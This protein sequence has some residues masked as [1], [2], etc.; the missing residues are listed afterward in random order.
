MIRPINKIDSLSTIIF[1][2]I[3]IIALRDKVPFIKNLDFMP[4]HFF[5]FN[6]YVFDINSQSD[7]NKPNA[8]YFI[9]DIKKN[10]TEEDL[11]SFSSKL[12]SIIAGDR[13]SPYEPLINDYFCKY[14]KNIF[15]PYEPK[16]KFSISVHYLINNNQNYKK[17]FEISCG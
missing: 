1:L 3:I 8:E 12:G 17:E 14:K 15:S 9:N 7:Q 6:M 5:Q 13:W 4:P 10:I 11:N 16:N 2:I